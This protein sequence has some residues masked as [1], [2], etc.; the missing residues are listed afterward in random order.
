MLQC[1]FIQGGADIL[2][3]VF[4]LLDLE[5]LMASVPYCVEG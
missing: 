3:T 5:W 4:P 1:V 2:D